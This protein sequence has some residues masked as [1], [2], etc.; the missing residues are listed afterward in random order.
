MLFD[1]PLF[2][3][4]ALVLKEQKEPLDHLLR[5]TAPHEWLIV[6]LLAMSVLLALSWAIF[7]RIEPTI[8]APC[9]LAAPGERH[10]VIAA[11]AGVVA[12]VL[13]GAG[14]RVESGQPIVR[15]DPTDRVRQVNA[16]Q[17]RLALLED[18]S[19]AGSEDSLRAARADL[20]AAR[21]MRVSGERIA[22][23]VAGEVSAMLLAP[24][25]VVT[26]GAEVARIRV[27]AA[28]RIEAMAFV[29]TDVAH[30]IVP[31]MKARVAAT[32][33]SNRAAGDLDAVVAAV[34]ARP[35]AV[36]RWLSEQGFAAPPRAHRVRLALSDDAS[37]PAVTG[38]THCAVR[39]IR[40]AVSPLRMLTAHGME[41]V[42][43][44]PGRSS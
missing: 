38:D 43:R 17:A 8:A 25:H 22:S 40:P 14:D 10:P 15:I 7:G 32:A 37:E 11:E 19:H 20:L 35:V 28:H 41:P 9:I 42:E 23:H 31:G 34:S 36:P 1:N 30:A 13:A 39:F 27:G 2:R 21:A 12:E 4:K 5:V 29:S 18:S 44:E 6:A 26:A 3:S 33:S 16:A 24:G